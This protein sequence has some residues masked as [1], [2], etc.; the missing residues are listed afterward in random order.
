MPTARVLD[1]LHALA[2]PTDECSDADHLRLFLARHDEAAFAELVRRHGP[3]VYGVCRRTLAGSPDADDAFQATF[4]V[5][6]RKAGTVRGNVGSWLYGVAV[7]VANKARVQ[8]VKRRVRHMA[9]AKPEAVHPPAPTADLWAVIDEELAKLPAELRQAVLACDV[10]GQ[11]RSQA[12][13]ALGSGD[14]FRRHP[15]DENV[16]VLIGPENSG[17]VFDFGSI[18]D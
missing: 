6:A 11:T 17:K 5:L 18:D 3:M 4:L 7:K 16:P 12:A 9:A 13:K 8:A 10:N 14:L 2:R 1:A 15:H